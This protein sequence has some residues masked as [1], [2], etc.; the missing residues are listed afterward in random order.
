[1]R[2]PKSLASRAVLAAVSVSFALS[3]VTAPVLADGERD[4]SRTYMQT[5]L[6]SDIP[7]LAAHTDPNLRNPW[8]RRPARAS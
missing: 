2:V 8:V 6:V 1:M 3:V 7:G 4:P 5:Y